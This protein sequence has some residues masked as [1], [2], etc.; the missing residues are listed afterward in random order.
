MFA[1]VLRIR[2]PITPSMRSFGFD[3]FL[4]TYCMMEVE[5]IHAKR[6][7]SILN[8]EFCPFLNRFGSAISCWLIN[9]FVYNHTNIIASGV[10]S[11]CDGLLTSYAFERD[12]A[13]FVAFIVSVA[14]IAVS[15]T[16]R[17]I[18]IMFC[19]VNFVSAFVSPLILY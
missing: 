3:C 8:L 4:F 17:N 12:C 14:N 6:V 18:P 15:F 16:I 9:N 7:G 5:I 1:G 13:G 11:I 10:N 2:N 19:S